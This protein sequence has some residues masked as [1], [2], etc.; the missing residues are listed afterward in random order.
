MS[1]QEKN[2]STSR[3]IP[4]R[5]MPDVK[6][7]FLL[8]VPKEHLDR[9][10]SMDA[11]G[12]DLACRLIT[13]GYPLDLEGMA[14]EAR[15]WPEGAEGRDRVSS[16]YYVYD[17]AVLIARSSVA[18]GLIRDPDTLANWLA[19]AKRKGYDVGHLDGV[20]IGSK[21][22]IQAMQKSVAQELSILDAI[23]DAGHEPQRLPKREAGK[24]GVKSEIRGRLVGKHRDFP[25]AGTQFDKAWE[26]LRAQGDIKEID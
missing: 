1:D 7:Q 16:A 9:W 11:W 25:K 18:A 15:D 6:N 12:L 10:L 24:P 2:E 19:W 17:R 13:L 22:A 21:P 23:R 20:D 26:R 8:G 14:K 3:V 4:E 5:L